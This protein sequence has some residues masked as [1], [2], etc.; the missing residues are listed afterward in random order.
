M[1]VLAGRSF[2]RRSVR[3]C[4]LLVVPDHGVVLVE[5]L[6]G[7]L[8]RVH[9]DLLRVGHVLPRELRY[10]LGHG[11]GEDAHLLL[12]L[13]AAED[14]VDVVDEAHVEHGVRLV[15]DHET[16]RAE[17]EPPALD[18]VDHPARGAD[19]DV[20][21]PPQL[22]SL[23]AY[24]LAAVDRDHPDAGV[25]A[26]LPHLLRYLDRQLPRRRQDERLDLAVLWVYRL[27]QGH[28]EGEGLSRARLGLP[29]HVLASQQRSYGPLLD[30]GGFGET[31][32]FDSP[33]YQGVEFHFFKGTQFCFCFYRNNRCQRI[34]S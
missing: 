20:G 11:G 21:S 2:W 33:H 6:D 12:P 10:L 23:R 28:R 29:Y 27:Q 18:V 13:D 16:D 15:Q 34:R 14:V 25:G 30:G 3:N 26:D 32:L 5:R 19:D 9:Q 7:G 8:V 31:H 24:R 1:I 17:V 22:L 4:E